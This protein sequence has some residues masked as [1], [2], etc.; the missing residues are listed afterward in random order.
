MT[1]GAVGGNTSPLDGQATANESPPADVE[2]RPDGALDTDTPAPAPA[3]QAPP[4]GIVS[5]Q[6]G[7]SLDDVLSPRAQNNL[8]TLAASLGIDPAKLL[9][10]VTSGQSLT[11][12]VSG[13][14][15]SGY[16]TTIAKSTGGGIA[17][18]QYA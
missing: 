18:D 8:A 6:Q 7:M 12:L 9:A 17:I 2:Q 5:Y 3:T 15:D 1:V 16:G 10:H 14:A 4:P 11:S 13:D